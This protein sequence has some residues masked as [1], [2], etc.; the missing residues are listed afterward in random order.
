MSAAEQTSVLWPV[1]LSPDE[2]ADLRRVLAHV[3]RFDPGGFSHT[4]RHLAAILDAPDRV[5]DH[6]YAYALAAHLGVSASEGSGL[7]TCPLG[8]GDEVPPQSSR[9]D[10]AAGERE[11]QPTEDRT[12]L[13]G[14][15]W[16]DG[17]WMSED[18]SDLAALIDEVTLIFATA[19]DLCSPR[20]TD[21]VARG[22]IATILADVARAS[23]RA[24]DQ[25]PL[26]V[27]GWGEHF[28]AQLL[29]LCIACGSN[30]NVDK[31][32]NSNGDRV[33]DAC[34]DAAVSG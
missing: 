17:V 34:S 25:F 31:W 19:T 12:P 1:L 21:H 32:C 8:A 10:P 13:G 30:D 29:G 2:K 26:D 5:P 15:P 23:R 9:P 6:T 24:F 3:E 11:Y 4:A 22:E 18:M 14:L 7:Q 28:K 16:R 27:K 20:S 33:C